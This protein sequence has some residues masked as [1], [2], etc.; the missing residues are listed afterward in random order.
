MFEHIGAE[1]AA[2]LITRDRE[3]LYAAQAP[4]M[5][6]RRELELLGAA[7]RAP[8]RSRATFRQA[9]TRVGAR[10]AEALSQPMA[11]GPQF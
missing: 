3:A 6:V 1:A 9:L 8:R 4:R 7:E 10:L 2:S 5:V 11:P